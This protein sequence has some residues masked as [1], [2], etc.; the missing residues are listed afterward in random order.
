MDSQKPR[1]NTINESWEELDELIRQLPLLEPST[2]FNHKVMSRI[3]AG[4]Y[5][6]PEKS[7]RKHYAGHML[8]FFGVLAMI[9][10][11]MTGILQWLL[12]STVELLA[13]IPLLESMNT[14][15]HAVVYRMVYYVFVPY[16]LLVDISVRMSQG[17]QLWYAI[18]IINLL[19]LL[20]LVHFSVRRI[21]RSSRRGEQ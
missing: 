9:H 1:K 15:Y 6:N 5:G 3:D 13:R 4:L 2:D 20:L 14:L 8:V 11:L 17:N 12:G 16:R 18:S 21:I 7:I 10:Y 19:L